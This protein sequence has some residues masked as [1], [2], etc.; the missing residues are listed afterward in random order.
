MGEPGHAEKEDVGRRKQGRGRVFVGGPG[1]SETVGVDVHAY[2][3]TSFYAC[4]FVRC[5]GFP[6]P[7]EREGTGQPSRGGF[8]R[9][10]L[11]CVVE[12]R[13]VVAG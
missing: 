12:V 5:R 8:L 2:P 1:R 11:V 4:L 13:F 10:R 6:S 9:P 7:W 3:K